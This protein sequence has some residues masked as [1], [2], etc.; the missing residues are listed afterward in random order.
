[1]GDP[2]GYSEGNHPAAVSQE[3]APRW[4]C[5]WSRWCTVGTRDLLT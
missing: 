4:E 2:E 3:E 5:W 1:M